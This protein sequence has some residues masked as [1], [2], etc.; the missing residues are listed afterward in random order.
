MKKKLKYDYS[1]TGEQ[2]RGLFSSDRIM[3]YVFVFD[4]Y[5]ESSFRNVLNLAM[6]IL[7]TEQSKKDDPSVKA[8]IGNK[9][10]DI[11]MNEFG[12]TKAYSDDMVLDGQAK[13]KEYSNSIKTIFGEE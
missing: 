1:T 7:K 9:R 3:G 6:R 8:F 2:Q 11:L 4:F 12:K 10:D 5:N 13:E